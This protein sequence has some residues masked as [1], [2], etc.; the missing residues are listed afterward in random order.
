MIFIACLLVISVGLYPDI[1]IL[2]GAFGSILGATVGA[3]SRANRWRI[4]LD[5]LGACVGFV[6]WFLFFG[7]TYQGIFISTSIGAI[8]GAIAGVIFI[9][10]K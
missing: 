9:K 4:L 1:L 6:L 5:L 8:I 7:E 10:Q 3:I 2:A